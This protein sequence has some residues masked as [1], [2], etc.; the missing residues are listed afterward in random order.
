[1]R[2]IRIHGFGGI[3]TMRLDEV[4]RPL[5]GVGEVLVAIKARRA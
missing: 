3:D 2:A 4:L 1:M 5:P